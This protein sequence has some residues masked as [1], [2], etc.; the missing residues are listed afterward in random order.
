MIFYILTVK[1]AFVGH[2]FV[3]ISTIIQIRVVPN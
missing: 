2:I 3:V 1:F